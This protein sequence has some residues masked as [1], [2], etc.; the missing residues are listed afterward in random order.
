MVKNDVNGYI[1]PEK[2]AYAL[3]KAV[4]AIVNDT[5]LRI[6]MEMESK[7]IIEEAFTYDHTAK[8][9]NEVIKQALSTKNY[10]CV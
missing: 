7:R 8:N 1:V 6:S 9:M 5:E 10:T 4:K 3:Y 2:D